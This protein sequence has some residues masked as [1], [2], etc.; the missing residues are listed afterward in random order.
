MRA[1]LVEH[2]IK[3]RNIRDLSAA[4]DVHCAIDRS[5]LLCDP[6]AG[7]QPKLLRKLFEDKVSC[8]LLRDLGCNLLHG[9]VCG[10]APCYRPEGRADCANNHLC[11]TPGCLCQISNTDNTE[12]DIRELT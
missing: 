2:G 3:I 8:L 5:K 9:A 7:F 11:Q 10:N 1:A 4:A 6:R 12:C